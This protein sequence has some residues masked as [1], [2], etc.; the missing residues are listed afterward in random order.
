MLIKTIKQFQKEMSSS[1]NVV[2]CYINN[3][4]T[5]CVTRVDPDPA[6]KHFFNTYIQTR[7]NF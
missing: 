1:N 5:S 3:I 7:S 6:G 2:K 4:P